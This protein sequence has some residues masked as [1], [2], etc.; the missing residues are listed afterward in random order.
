M[1]FIHIYRFYG[2]GEYENIKQRRNHNN[3][4]LDNIKVIYI[5]F[6]RRQKWFDL[7]TEGNSVP[8]LFYDNPLK[9]R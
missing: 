1:Y 7:I 2:N 8:Y 5:C 4:S 3:A 9:E 6:S